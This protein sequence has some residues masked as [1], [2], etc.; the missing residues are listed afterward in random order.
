MF[1]RASIDADRSCGVS[2]PSSA[3]TYRTGG[4]S[5]QVVRD[6]VIETRNI[7]VGIHS[8]AATEV[9]SG[10]SEGDIIVA[11]AGT[12]LRDGDRVKPIDADPTNAQAR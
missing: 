8:G 9:R 7:Q 3:V 11:N 1:A 6:N 5:V 4:T 10:L 2:V 12:S